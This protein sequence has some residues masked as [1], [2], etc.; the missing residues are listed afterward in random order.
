MGFSKR[1]RFLIVLL[2]LTALWMGVYSL[3]IRPNHGSYRE[4][5]ERLEMRKE[6]QE[7]TELYLNHYGELEEQLA[8]LEQNSGEESFFYQDIDDALMDRSLQK[9]AG[10][11]G[12]KI[13]RMSVGDETTIEAPGSGEKAKEKEGEKAGEKADEKQA[14]AKASEIREAGDAQAQEQAQTPEELGGQVSGKEE[15]E[16]LEEA[17][18]RETVITM[19]VESPG[20]QE[21]MAFADALYREQKSVLL[22]Y[23][24]VEGEYE[25]DSNGQRVYQGMKGMMEVRYYYE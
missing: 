17:V 11:A 22:T 21:I 19:E 6:D 16:G 4:T 24:D 5:M 15:A 3:L 14:G 12:V 8:L 1:E 2:M 18:I 20:A 9:M 25:T 13:R 7:V 10:Q 23:L